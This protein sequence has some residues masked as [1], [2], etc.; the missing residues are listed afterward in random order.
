MSSDQPRRA[1]ETIMGLVNTSTDACE[2]GY[3]HDDCARAPPRGRILRLGSMTTGCGASSPE[4]SAVWRAAQ[5]MRREGL[6]K[7]GVTDDLGVL[8]DVVIRT[9]RECKCHARSA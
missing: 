8:A 1:L 6:V 9:R 3:R 2:R 5:A 4:S 7:S